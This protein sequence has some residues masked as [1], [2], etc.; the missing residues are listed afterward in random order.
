MENRSLNTEPALSEHAFRASY[1]IAGYIRRTLT[2]EEEEELDAW[3]DADAAHMR[4][5][6]DLTDEKR[7]QEYLYWY[8]QRSV[9]EKLMQARQRLQL[10][11]RKI[12][13]IWKYAAAACLFTAVCTAAY[14]YLKRKESVT[15]LVNNEATDIG[16]GR[17]LATLTI[18][19]QRVIPITSDTIIGRLASVAN[20]TITYSNDGQEETQWQE[21]H[22]PRKAHYKLLLPDGSR[23]WLNSESSI[24]FP[25]RFT[26]GKREVTVSGE[27]YFEV[28]K[29]SLLPFIVSV[30]G[31][32]VQAL[33]TA[34]NIHAYPDE[35]E[36]TATLV[37]GSVRV[38]DENNTI[39][40]QPSQ[41]VE[42]DRQGNW[43]LHHDIETTPLIAW[44]ENRFRFRNTHFDEI[45]RMIERWYDT[46]V[47]CRDKIDFHFNGTISRDVP[48]SRLLKLLEETGHVRFSIGEG[49]VTV[50]Q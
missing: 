22:I 38:F 44:K 21:I 33:G 19:G 31:V 11:T 23:V 49:Q 25:S 3:L 40:L 29:D 24:R 34:F 16:P 9:E 32:K 50:L 8:D 46:R 15:L 43:Q 10:T 48:L 42:I 45:A 18:D 7:M 28:A 2:M 37:E 14:F 27:A 26:S 20:G 17:Q 5:F 6:E 41:Q 36:F 12:R 30:N 4:L 39:L 1:L 13:S 47:V 35:P